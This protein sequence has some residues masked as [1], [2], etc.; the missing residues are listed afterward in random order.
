MALDFFKNISSK[1]TVN[2][3]VKVDMMMILGVYRFVIKN[4]AYQTLKRQSSYKWQEINRIGSNPTLQ[5]T[6]FGVETIE[7]EG[8]IYPHFKGGLKHVT[9]M[10]AEAGLGKAL[11]LISGNGFAFG[12]WCITKI[13]ENQSNFLNDGVPRKIEFTLTLKRY[14]EDKKKGVKGIIQ[15]VIS[16]L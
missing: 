16:S 12:R 7:L 2:S 3:L 8:V 13:T 10:R 11:F 6:G 4:A 9:L 15:N 14:G 5:F 1:L